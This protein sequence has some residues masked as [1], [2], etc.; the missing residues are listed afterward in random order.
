MTT[1]C[2]SVNVGEF[3]VDDTGSRRFWPV[4]VDRIGGVD[5]SGV[6]AQARA[7]WAEDAGFTLTAE[8]EA[9]RD[10]GARAV[11][12]SQSAVQEKLRAYWEAHKTCEDMF[13]PMNRTDILEMLGFRNPSNKL[14][15]EAGQLLSDMLGKMRTL[16]GKQRCWAFPFSEF[17]HDSRTWR[18]VGHLRLITDK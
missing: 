5:V 9:L 16:D 12:T 14:V 7:W 10:A 4:A 8:E 18:A 13:R 6:W 17:A 15:S 1:F 3:L 2:G 11:H